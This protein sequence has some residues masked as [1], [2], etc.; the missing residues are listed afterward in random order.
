MNK[1][2]IFIPFFFVGMAALVTWILMLLWNWL[3]PAI[4]DLITISFWQAAGILIL[5]KILFGGFHTGKR[6]CCCGKSKHQGW[7]HKFKNKWANMSE[8][9][10]MRWESKFAGTAY[11]AAGQEAEDSKLNTDAEQE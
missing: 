5:S 6:G 7:K 11:S 3:M 10:K 1:K 9:D 2:M 8:E 4:F